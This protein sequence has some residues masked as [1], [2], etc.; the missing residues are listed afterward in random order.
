MNVDGTETPPRIDSDTPE[1]APTGEPPPPHDRE[2]WRTRIDSIPDTVLL[3]A[4]QSDKRATAFIFAG[5]QAKREHLARTVVRERIPQHIARQPAFGKALLEAA[6]K[7]PP[8]K[9]PREKLPPK[10]LPA[11]PPPEPSATPATTKP[12]PS[13][14]AREREK[15]KEMR[16]RIAELEGHL[17][18]AE[19]RHAKT[20]S[21][22]AEITAKQERVR[23]A[24]DAERERAEREERR[25]RRTS[26]PK[27][28]E[29]STQV[30]AKTAAQTP[31]LP[32]ES[33]RVEDP[34]KTWCSAIETV[35]RDR[36][37]GAAVQV[38]RAFLKEEMP[39]ARR[40]MAL[41]MLSKACREVGDTEGW[42]ESSL[43]AAGVRAELGN[44]GGALATLL[45]SLGP[46]VDA[47]RETKRSIVLVRILKLAKRDDRL[48]EA[49]LLLGRFRIRRP[50][51]VDRISRWKAFEDAKWRTVWRD[52]ATPAPGFVI[53]REEAIALPSGNPRL[54]STTPRDLARAVETGDAALVA[55]ARGAIDRLAESRPEVEA[56]LLVAIRTIDPALVEPLLSAPLRAAVVDASNVARHEADPLAHQGSGR[57]AHLTAM[58]NHL[59]A[60]RFFPVRFIADASLGRIID[61]REAYRRWLDH[62]IV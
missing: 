14:L 2:T 39:L 52:S 44:L 35:L 5:F 23:R 25:A 13:A 12:E 33:P 30:P 62:G 19:A 54:A 60:S 4:I 27:S 59:L 6:A 9:P 42:E 17:K 49:S 48:A 41:E 21:D 51:M 58:R 57:F 38:L 34:D 24:Q 28:A 3:A 31:A 37:A 1:T 45:D 16:R 15:T 20:R 10:E 61:D 36:H 43:E 29:S 7:A 26:E 55:D 40:A 8:Q 18:E 47:E 32:S 56:A 50:A 53:G 11:P 22:L 46:E